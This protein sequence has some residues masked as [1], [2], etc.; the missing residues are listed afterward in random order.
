MQES[1]AIARKYLLEAKN[2]SKELYDRTSQHQNIIKGSRVLLQDKTSKNKLMSRWLGQYEV[3]HVE[4]LTRNVVINKKGKN[5]TIHQ[6]LLKP[7]HEVLNRYVT[8]RC[9][10]RKFY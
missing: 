5:Q 10:H 1:Q 4:P 6:N 7:F 9:H 8:E 2:K 3:I